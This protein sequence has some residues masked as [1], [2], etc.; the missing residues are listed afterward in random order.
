[1]VPVDV[2]D[3]PLWSQVNLNRADL[4]ASA[5]DHQKD[6]VPVT[7]P[8]TGETALHWA[9]RDNQI[10]I[11]PCGHL[12]AAMILLEHGV[13]VDHVD[14]WHA[15]ALA[16]AQ[17][18]KNFDIAVSLVEANATVDVK[19][20]DIQKLFFAAIE[21]QSATA[22]EKLLARGADALAKNEEGKTAMDLAKD[23][24][25]DDVTH[26]VAWS[27]TFYRDEASLAQRQGREMRP[28]SLRTGSAPFPMPDDV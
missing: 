22:V 4:V 25:D 12:E 9:V 7:E 18:N 28:L 6:K 14:Q 20:V 8:G 19:R 3:L 17:S 16:I 23:A 24:G 11:L 5:V 15:T 26:L 13:K 27:K 10:E 2:E 1:M 21:L